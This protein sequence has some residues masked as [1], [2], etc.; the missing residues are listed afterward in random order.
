MIQMTTELESAMSIPR[1]NVQ[2]TP[3]PTAAGH[4]MRRLKFG[5]TVGAVPQATA[6]VVLDVEAPA[7]FSATKFCGVVGVDPIVLPP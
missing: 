3:A 5:G 6:A 1:G 4:E 2:M 7:S